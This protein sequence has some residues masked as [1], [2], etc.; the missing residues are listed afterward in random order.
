MLLAIV[1][2]LAPLALREFVHLRY[3][4]RPSTRSSGTTRGG[5]VTA[6]T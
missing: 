1:L 5:H 4:P 6:G 3:V 2:L